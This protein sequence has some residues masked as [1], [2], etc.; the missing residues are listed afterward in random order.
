MPL[1]NTLSWSVVPC[2]NSTSVLPRYSYSF[3]ETLEFKLEEV[4][5]RFQKRLS[6]S[7]VR[8]SWQGVV[9]FLL[10]LSWVVWSCIWCL[11][12]RYILVEFYDGLTVHSR[13]FC[14]NDSQHNKYQL[15][16]WSILCCL[17]YQ[18]TRNPWW[19]LK[20]IL[21]YSLNGFFKLWTKDDIW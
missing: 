5:E 17:K 18:R 15:P 21:S 8:S 19:K 2:D 20:N 11:S 4:G 1:S 9:L 13:F 6:S 14:Q 10:I 3:L 16:K 7:W 12:S